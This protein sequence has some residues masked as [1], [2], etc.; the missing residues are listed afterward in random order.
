MLTYSGNYKLNNLIYSQVVL[1]DIITNVPAT[2]KDPEV[3]KTCKEQSHHLR[4]QIEDHSPG[5]PGWPEK[6]K[7]ST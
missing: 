7:S 4:G 6:P 2:L 1:I 5:Q 3:A